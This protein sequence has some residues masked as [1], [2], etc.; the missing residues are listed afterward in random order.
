M[1]GLIAILFAND[2]N[3][4]MMYSEYETL[5]PTHKLSDSS[6]NSSQNT[7]SN[8]KELY[9][10]ASLAQATPAMKQ[11]LNIRKKYSSD[12][13]LFYRMGDFYELF[14][15][16]AI[17]ASK[18]L[19]IALTQRG[20]HLGSPIKMCGVPVVSADTYLQRLITA[21]IRVVVCEQLEKPMKGKP[22]VNRGVVRLITPGTITEGN[23]LSA[24]QNHFLAC[25]SCTKKPPYSITYADISTGEILTFSGSVSEINDCLARINAKEVI[26]QDSLSANPELFNSFNLNRLPI[27]PIVNEQFRYHRSLRTVLEHYQIPDISVL[28]SFNEN[29]IIATGVLLDYVG[30]TQVNQ[31]T[32]LQPLKHLEQSTFMVLGI[33]ALQSLEI[34][35][36]T[37]EPSLAKSINKCKS[38]AGN[39]QLIK[40]LLHPLIDKDLI[41]E[42][43]DV[44]EAFILES[45]LKTRLSKIIAS[46]GDS[47]RSLTR[48]F[49]GRGQPRDIFLQSQL[50]HSTKKIKTLIQSS[51]I[52]NRSE[53]LKTLAKQLNCCDLLLQELTKA[54]EV[55][56]PPN[57]RGGV[58]AYGYSDKLDS[59]RLTKNDN[60]KKI[61]A[62]ESKYKS[63]TGISRLSI[64]HNNILGSYVEIPLRFADK[65]DSSF[66]HKHS[67]SQALRYHTNELT[68]LY[69]KVLNAEEHTLKIEDE[70]IQS[71]IEQLK[72]HQ[73]HIN[74]NTENISKLDV[75]IG[76][77]ELAQEKNLC[78]P[79]II[80]DTVLKISGGR[81]IVVEDSL[82]KQGKDF[83]ANDIDISDTEPLILLTGPNMAG[84]STY[85][86]Q[87]AIITVMAQCGCFVPAK[88]ALIGLVD[89]I[90]TRIGAR[91]NI[92]HGQSTFM[93]EMMET[94]AIINQASPR[95]LIILDELGRG[96]STYDGLA[97]AWALL[98]HIRNEMG[99]RT[100]FSTH[101]SELT[102]LPLT[103]KGIKNL[104]VECKV[105]GENIHFLHTVVPGISE[106]SLGL[107]V[108]K[109]AGIPRHIINEAYKI[110]QK[111]EQASSTN[112]LSKDSKSESNSNVFSSDTF[113]KHHKLLKTINNC[114]PDTLTPKQALDILY[115][116]KKLYTSNR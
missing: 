55:D 15:N 108:A 27:T 13:L 34:I 56:F 111:L 80:T 100:L 31:K 19:G 84:K 69:S 37:K 64:S 10:E 44:I 32:T 66:V 50:L 28:G 51:T 113:K 26:L 95:S 39:R 83:I 21:G 53:F 90:M 92:S 24:D 46:V 43:H 78:R 22:V 107:H 3:S 76:W 67:T 16:D 81:H 54:L 105:D 72:Q 102:Q 49:L 103:V 2:K 14:F 60:N 70:I 45:E 75:L 61:R 98:I 5:S 82:N 59:W 88:Y 91:D 73:K 18:I 7:S 52:I 33:D 6:H 57:F 41:S 115:G 68:E 79:E 47:E 74:L 85:L 104:Q 17:K 71:L 20:S 63:K 77:T 96:T 116:L 65:M 23:I 36:S 109:L 94:A 42:R 110:Q 12:Y 48:L 106:S 89:K 38:P 25:I 87:T 11:F 9:S 8:L 29:E 30:I 35:N 40:W 1:N 112:K 97:L 4:K 86:R 93:I 101:Y 99:C 114:Q 62:L 58:I